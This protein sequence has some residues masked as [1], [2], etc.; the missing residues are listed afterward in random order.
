VA[1]VSGRR[2]DVDGAWR[3]ASVSL[4]AFAGQTIHLRFVATD[5]GPDNLLEVQLDDIRVTQP[6]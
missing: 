6:S 3:T 5:G 2:I 4:D 1:L